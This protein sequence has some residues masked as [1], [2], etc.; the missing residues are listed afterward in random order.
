MNSYHKEKD[1]SEKQFLECFRYNDVFLFEQI[2]SYNCTK[3][4][5]NHYVELAIENDASSILQLLLD[6][7]Q[8]KISNSLPHSLSYCIEMSSMECF[9]KLLFTNDF[10]PNDKNSFLL[11]VAI[12]CGEVEML[13]LMLSNRRTIINPKELEEAFYK[14]ARSDHYM[15]VKFLMR[16][17][18][19]LE[20]EKDDNQ[21]LRQA[22]YN[23]SIDTALVLLYDEY[24]SFDEEM[25]LCAVE[26]ECLP[27]VIAFLDDGRV[28]P[29]FNG[30][31]LL[32]YAIKTEYV[33]IF[34]AIY[35]DY[36]VDPSDN[37]SHSLSVAVECGNDYAIKTLLKDKRIDV[38]AN[39]LTAL[40]Y[41]IETSNL[42]IVNLVLN[43]SQRL[44]YNSQSLFNYSIELGNYDIFLALFNSHH[45]IKNYD[46]NKALVLS[47]HYS[48]YEIFKKL[49]NHAEVSATIECLIEVC[50]NNCIEIFDE[51]IKDTNLNITESENDAFI[52]AANNENLYMF[53]ELLNTKEVDISDQENKALMDA[54]TSN[55]INITKALLESD[56]LKDI[57]LN[58]ILFKTAKSMCFDTL[59]LLMV[60]HRTNPFSTDFNESILTFP[61][62]CGNIDFVK[63]ILNYKT[64]EKIDTL[65]PLYAACLNDH[66]E[67]FDLIM[68]DKRYSY[69]LTED[70]DILSIILKR[71]NNFKYAELFLNET[72]FNYNQDLIENNR[73]S[74]LSL[75]YP[76]YRVFRLLVDHTKF[77]FTRYHED[78]LH[79]AISTK[80]TD[81]IKYLFNNLPKKPDIDLLLQCAIYG[82]TETFSALINKYDLNADYQEAFLISAG[83]GNLNIVNLCLEKDCVVPE[84]LNNQ[85]VKKAFYSKHIN[86]YRRLFNIPQVKKSLLKS[87]TRIYEQISKEM[88]NEA[89]KN[90]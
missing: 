53:T 84:L 29:N 9:T 12:I 80:N 43:T 82:N 85:A 73:Y 42:E 56:K 16:K 34:Q 64:N 14:A 59:D 78:L 62:V 36:R 89:I 67:I 63:K 32:D 70:N 38:N 20:P 83:N 33:D 68:Q 71:E 69:K 86:V 19:I 7:S 48:N 50:E 24:V 21:A 51:L 49:Y 77:N 41:A 54:S 28:N 15:M 57:N 44:Y 1:L 23:N 65:H 75:K 11:K 25:F 39:G 58:E 30:N 52:T 60:D 76:D 74:Q 26:Q 46:E 55:N 61:A 87:E 22:V 10:D 45:I 37:E 13:K 79:T 81:I 18:I 47:C 35:Y 40:S 88:L 3:F 6:F 66:F 4:E 2:Y 27:L 5:F 31:Q 8:Y 72:K 17:Q 90:F